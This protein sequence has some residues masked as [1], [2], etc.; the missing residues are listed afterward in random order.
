MNHE[1]Y[2]GS[3]FPNP[4][5]IFPFNPIYLPSIMHLEF[6]KFP[7]NLSTPAVGEIYANFGF[8]FTCIYIM[9]MP[10]FIALIERQLLQS[11]IEGVIKVALVVYLSLLVFLLAQTSLFS[12]VF[13]LKH[14]A[15]ILLVSIIFKFR[16]GYEKNI[17]VN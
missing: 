6:M 15:F 8:T 17:N 5:G 1:L 10:I 12:S 11:Q 2:L 7:G 16:I 13:E 14:I 4:G 3:T 9:L